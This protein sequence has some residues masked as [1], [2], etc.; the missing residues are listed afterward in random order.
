MLCYLWRVDGLYRAQV[1]C[2]I[3]RVTPRMLDHWIRSEVIRPTKTYR[4]T[5]G[6]R[7]LFLF[8][9]DD[10]L[11]IRVV[12][13]LREAGL[14]LQQ[15]RKAIRR[16]R[17]LS[18]REWSSKWLVSVGDRLYGVAT[19][20]ALETLS[21]RTPGQ[22]AFAVIALGPTRET[23]VKDLERQRP[24]ETARLRGTLHPFGSRKAG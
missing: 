9:F 11:R 13:A 7:D 19:P 8:S 10:L 15:I 24:V 1:A 16:L 23:L 17:S 12:R 21:G 22:L 3:C 4:A 5:P 20:N 18:G 6:G 14:S 2:R